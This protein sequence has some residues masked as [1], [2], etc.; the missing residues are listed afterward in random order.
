MPNTILNPAQLVDEFKKSGEFDRLRRELLTEFRDAA[1]FAAFMTRVEDITRR[2]LTEEGKI[3][4]MSETS[5]IRE[6]TQELNRY[7]LVERTVAETPKLSD[8]TFASA[9]RE[10]ITRILHEDRGGKQ[11]DSATPSHTGTPHNGIGDK[12]P[13]LSVQ[14]QNSTDD[15]GETSATQRNGVVTKADD[16]EQDG[17]ESEDSAMLESPLSDKNP[18]EAAS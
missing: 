4:T 16:A 15:Q 13:S 3:L 12:K 9:V 10:S 6:L 7:P 17:Y 2:K 5:V 11:A 18:L 8:P 14:I 1:G